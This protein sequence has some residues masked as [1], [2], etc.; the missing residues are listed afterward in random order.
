MT[1]RIR[2]LTAALWVWSVMGV[3]GLHAQVL[4]IKQV[5]LIVENT[6]TALKA[7][8]TGACL[9]SDYSDM[10][11][12]LALVQLRNG[13]PRSGSGLIGNFVVDRH[14]GRIWS[15]I[16]RTNEVDSAHLRVLRRKLL[17]K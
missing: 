17:K 3:T 1:S 4:D 11:P 8:H 10:G 9:S 15:D 13:C 16:D 14:S 2:V 7:K 12:D 5:K 6:P